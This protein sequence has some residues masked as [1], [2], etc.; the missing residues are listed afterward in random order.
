MHVRRGGAGWGGGGG[1]VNELTREIADIFLHISIWP[2]S[3]VL[4]K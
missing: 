4:V 1:G 3:F 2:G